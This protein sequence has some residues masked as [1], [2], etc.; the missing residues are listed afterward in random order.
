MTPGSIQEINASATNILNQMQKFFTFHMIDNY[1][2]DFTMSG[3]A[4]EYVE[5]KIKAFFERQTPDGIRHDTYIL[6]YSGDVYEYGDW[7]M[8]GT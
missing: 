4:M 5:L 2:C 6:Y 3:M 1:G 8:A 7:A